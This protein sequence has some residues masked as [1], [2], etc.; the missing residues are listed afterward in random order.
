[1]R[2]WFG[3]RCL[4]RLCPGYVKSDEQCVWFECST[5]GKQ[6]GHTDYKHLTALKGQHDLHTWR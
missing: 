3:F 4:L 6:T 2:P 5:C 1:M